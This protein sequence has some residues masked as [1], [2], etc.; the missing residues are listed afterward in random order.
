MDQLRPPHSVGIRGT[1]HGRSQLRPGIPKSFVADRGGRLSGGELVRRQPG[2]HACQDSPPRAPALRLLRGPHD[3]QLWRSLH[4]GRPCALRVHRSVYC[5]WPAGWVPSALHTVISRG[6]CYGRVPPFILEFR[7]DRIASPAGGRKPG[8][9][10]LAT[11]FETSISPLRY[12][13]VSRHYRHGRDSRLLRYPQHMAVVSRGVAPV[14]TA[15]TSGGSMIGRWLKFN[16]VGGMGV[17]V[18]LATLAI[19]KSLLHLDYLAATAGAVEA[20]ILHNFFWH[21]RFTWPNQV[22]GLWTTRMLKFN[23]TTGA[24]SLAANLVL[25]TLLVGNLHIQYLAA[26]CLA[27]GSGSLLNFVISDR[28]V[29]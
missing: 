3:R 21:E 17:G 11:R 16:A 29:S 7:A 18:Q 14:T 13:R 2:W 4:H 10:A 25:M 8:A 5:F 27:I 23:L 19:L 22:R 1:N 9:A 26:N 20:A 28:F 15:R 12:R 6:L 24:S